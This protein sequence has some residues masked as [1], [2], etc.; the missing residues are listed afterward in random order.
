MHKVEVVTNYCSIVKKLINFYCSRSPDRNKESYKNKAFAFINT[1]ENQV[2]EIT[3]PQLFKRREFINAG[4]HEPLIREIKALDP[5][6]IDDDDG[7]NVLKSIISILDQ[8][9]EEEKKIILKDIKMLLQ[10]Y[11]KYLILCKK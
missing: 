7:L 8:S 4:N 10:L 11:I 5:R 9:T 1:A 3:G 2:L 6:D